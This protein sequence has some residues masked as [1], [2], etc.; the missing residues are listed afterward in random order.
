MTVGYDSG[1]PVGW[2]GRKVPPS[3]AR[4]AR[5]TLAVRHLQGLGGGTAAATPVS[6]VRMRLIPL[7]LCVLL[8]GVAHAEDRVAAARR[9][10][11]EA[12]AQS[13]SAAGVA[14][15]P[16]E[17]YVRAFKLEREVEVW[18]GARG[19]PLVRVKVYPVCAASGELGPKRQEGDLQVPEGFYLL[20][21]FNPLSSFHLSMRVSYPN[22]SDRKLSDPRRPG[23]NIAIHGNCVSMGCI[24][25]EDGPIEE[26]ALAPAGVPALRAEPPPAPRGRGPQEWGV[27]GAGWKV[28]RLKLL[29]GFSWPGRCLLRSLLGHAPLALLP[30]LESRSHRVQRVVLQPLVVYR[31]VVL[32][33]DG[34][35][36]MGVGGVA[37]QPLLRLPPGGERGGVWRDSLRGECS[38]RRLDGIVAV[39]APHIVLADEPDLSSQ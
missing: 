31:E 24:A 2:R 15:P 16:E 10:R 33:G 37:L 12:L 22:D 7:V 30:G 35:E 32:P 20:D 5:G 14:W 23:G 19:K 1:S 29:A 6:H 13:L 4:H 11:Q 18:A 17:L 38:Q 36:S 9:A 39:H 27:H 34:N 8:G 3:A 26:L 25:I 28:G 21:S